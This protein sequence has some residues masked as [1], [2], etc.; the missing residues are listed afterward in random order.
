MSKKKIKS[1][2]YTGGT[3][4]SYNKEIEQVI[5]L[6]F[7]F[8]DYQTRN[9]AEKFFIQR[10]F[11]V[12]SS[13]AEFNSTNFYKSG[14][15]QYKYYIKISAVVFKKEEYLRRKK[16]IDSMDKSSASTGKKAVIEK[17]R[18]RLNTL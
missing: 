4:Q 13:W 6:T 15:T 18:R 2:T 17:L 5:D 3:T 12:K 8:P 16:I 9:K 7:E 10:G 14:F 1:L 11:T